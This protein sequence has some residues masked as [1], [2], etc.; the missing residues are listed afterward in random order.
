VPGIGYE[1][2]VAWYRAEM[3]EGQDFGPWDWCEVVA[4]ESLYRQIYSQGPR[5]IL[6]VAVIPQGPPAVVIGADQSGPC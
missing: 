3:P 5:G 2:L 1:E 6:G 4:E